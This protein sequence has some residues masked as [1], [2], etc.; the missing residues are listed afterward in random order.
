M[1]E[2]KKSQI[3]KAAKIG[4]RRHSAT[5]P[6]AAKISTGHSIVTSSVA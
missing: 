1:S 2:T 6:I 5:A 3:R 4:Q